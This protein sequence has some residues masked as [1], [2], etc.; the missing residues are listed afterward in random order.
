M[1]V[2]ILHWAIILNKAHRDD[3]SMMI[4]GCIVA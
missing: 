1:R 4:K 3:I 2:T